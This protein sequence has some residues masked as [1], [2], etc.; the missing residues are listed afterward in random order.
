MSEACPAVRRR[1]GIGV[2][3][4][5]GA[6]RKPSTVMTSCSPS[7]YDGR[8]RDYNVKIGL[9]P[10]AAIRRQVIRDAIY[11]LVARNRYRWFGRRDAFIPSNSN[12][13]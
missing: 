11:D 3:A 10:P 12:R 1:I 7:P 2:E 5:S 6:I 4:A 9:H 8:L 13:S